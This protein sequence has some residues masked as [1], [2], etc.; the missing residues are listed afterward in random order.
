M[1]CD[2]NGGG[3]ESVDDVVGRD[4]YRRGYDGKDVNFGAKDYGL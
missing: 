3:K 1:G 4:E 2:D